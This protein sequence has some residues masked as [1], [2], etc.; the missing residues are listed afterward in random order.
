VSVHYGSRAER[1]V[2]DR[3]PAIRSRGF[4]RFLLLRGLLAWG[5][6]MTIA[7]AVMVSLRLGLDHPRLPMVLGFTVSLCATAG[8]LWAALT[9]WINER[10]FHSLTSDRIQ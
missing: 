8:L 7:M 4:G 1:W 3:W 10:I 2:R 9:W 5:G 6:V